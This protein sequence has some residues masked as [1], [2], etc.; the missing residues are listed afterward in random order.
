MRLNIKNPEANRL[1]RELV[2]VTGESITAAV[3]N[4]V[5]VRLERVNKAETRAD[6]TATEAPREPRPASDRKG[7]QL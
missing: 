3:T 1:A 6:P 5:R 7:G 4:A 2:A